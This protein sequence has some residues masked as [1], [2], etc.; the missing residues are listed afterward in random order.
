MSDDRRGGRGHGN[1]GGHGGGNHGGHGGGNH[2]GGNGDDRH[3]QPPSQLGEKVDWMKFSHQDLYNMVHT[4]VDLKAAGSAQADWA[5][6]GK[7]LDEV[8]GLLAKAITQSQQ[9]WSGESAD[10][11]REALESVE[12]WALNTS[13]HADNVAKCIGDEIQH[14]ETARQ[15]M[16]APSP[17]PPT[18]TPVTGG[19]T[20]PVGTQPDTRAA[21]VQ[22]QPAFRVPSHGAGAQRLMAD[23]RG[24][25]LSGLRTVP[26]VAPT[27]PFVG[28]ENV[29]APV[30]DSVVTADATHRQ[31]AE[32]MALFQQNSYAVDR[33]VPSFSPPTNPV[34][35]TP[36]PAVVVTP[37]PVAPPP[38]D[39]GPGP[40]VAPTR[41]GPQERGATTPSQGRGGGGSFGRGGFVGGRG[42]M[43]V[44]VGS[45]GGGG[46]GGPAPLGPPG[47]GSGILNERS[48]GANPGGVTSQF[49]A[50]KSVTP[51]HGMI[52]AAPMAAPPP[53]A[54]TPGGGGNER[55]RPGYLED[56]D[57]VF[58]VDRKAAPPV[59]GL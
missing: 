42:P 37:G 44:P 20:P 23:D 27:S 25:D 48:G 13:G 7:A 38:P 34:A 45:G 56:D 26:P 22:Q 9:A 31:A 24:G 55:S 43:P 57:N 5:A 40:V 35:P 15:M 17:A 3:E 6:V 47:L 14:V 10:R 32:V 8:Q 11:A 19:V 33:T 46:G 50:P 4:G 36:P 59:I 39:G 52:G 30:V 1:H 41:P 53:V 51:Q 12:K 2:G 58:G 28:L 16:P 29:A 18:I 54:S 21:L 49:Q